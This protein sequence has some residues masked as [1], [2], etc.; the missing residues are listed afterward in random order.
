[1]RNLCSP[2]GLASLVILAGAPAL[3]AQSTL[4][5]N[6][7]IMVKDGAGKA[8]PGAR[9]EIT[10]DKLMGK[11]VGVTDATGM[12]RAPQ[13][14]PG[15]YTTKISKDGFRSKGVMR[16]VDLGGN[17]SETVSLQAQD[18]ASTTVDVVAAQGVMDKSDL[19]VKANYTQAD[20]L[21]LPV[22]RTMAGIAQLAPAVT[23]GAGGRATIG[24]AATYENK[25]LVNGADVNDNYFNTD[26][27]LYIED[28]VEETSVMLN[29]V[30][31]EYGRFTGGVV[32][33]VTKRGSNNFEGSFRTMLSN[34]KWNA[35]VPFDVREKVVDKLNQTHV[36]TFGGP[37]VKDKLWFFLAARS[38]A[39]DT[40]NNLPYTGWQYTTKN[41]E[42]R[43]E[44]NLTWQIND[45][46]RLLGVINTRT[47]DND[48]RAPLVNNTADLHGLSTRH[49]P[50]SRITI[51]YDA[52]LSSSLN[53]NVT[54]AQKLQKITTKSSANNGGT[55]FWQS[56]VFDYDGALFNNH[57]FGTDPEER[58]NESL[59]AMLSYYFQAAGQHELKVGGEIFKEINEGANK[60]SPTGYVLDVMT[61][62]Y[63]PAN[64][65]LPITYDVTGDYGYLEDWTKSPGGKFTATY[66]SFFIQDNWTVNEKLSFNLGVRYEGFKGD[67]PSGAKKPNT[68][69]DFVPRLSVNYDLTGDGKTLLSASYAQYAGKAN[70]AITT[71]GSYVGN[72]AAYYYWYIGPEASGVTPGPNAPGFRRSDYDSTPFYVSD[73][74]LNTV[75]DKDFKTPMTY[76]HTL[77]LRRKV[78]NGSVTLAYVHRN[79]TRMFE[80]YVGYDG[81]VVLADGSKADV[82]RWGN[83]KDEEADRTYRALTAEFENTTEIFG[84]K[85]F[86]RG[87]LTISRLWG[88]YEGDGGN[89]PGGGTSIGNYDARTRPGAVAYGYL[90]SDEP[91]AFK[92]QGLYSRSIGTGTLAIGLTFNYFTGKPYNL[93]RTVSAIPNAAFPQESDSNTY[94]RYYGDRGVGRFP[95]IYQSDLSVQ[96]DGK[97]GFGGAAER[98]G[99]FAKLTVFNWLNNIQQSGF[100]TRALGGSYAASEWKPRAD[101]GRATRATHYFGA[102][103]IG[104]DLGLRF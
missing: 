69:G 17:H 96:W 66:T 44:A 61:A 77:R 2:L 27:G 72:P 50:L 73:P 64:S 15:E 62:N 100:E 3:V 32:N 39:N 26:T 95:S 14:P 20:I 10:S 40:T 12:F 21:K 28:A 11:R 86:Y 83:V 104:I 91:V 30:S 60:Q 81:Y 51:A 7:T 92:S 24:G 23:T 67:A 56:P 31:A 8:L 18:V 22:G 76:E 42:T 79:Y 59:K 9:V 90:P 74:V 93:T 84:G 68:F 99:Y 6:L 19:T 58:N 101:F 37:I 89:S 38:V 43:L 49:D 16:K 4:T 78:G 45:N 5:G 65:G 98:V 88:N 29:N 94:T 54:F 57:Y 85:L 102:R 80:D 48:N 33:A 75:H 97:F 53:L 36:F 13:L 103:T 70:A 52:I 63:D 1:M 55:A 87:N 82:I 71:A 41:K 35:M 46:H 25:F 34:N 47:V